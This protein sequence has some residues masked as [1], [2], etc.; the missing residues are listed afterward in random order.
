MA[1]LVCSQSKSF[2]GKIETILKSPFT[3]AQ[4]FMETDLIAQLSSYQATLIDYNAVER[5][6]FAQRS[7]SPFLWNVQYVRTIWVECYL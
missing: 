5:K 7:I 1:L 3:E 2:T 4:M 6:F